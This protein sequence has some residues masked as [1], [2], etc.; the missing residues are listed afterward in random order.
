MGGLI[1]LLLGW[2]LFALRAPLA[3][4]FLL[5]LLGMIWAAD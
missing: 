4:W 3:V 2:I 1:I 5:L